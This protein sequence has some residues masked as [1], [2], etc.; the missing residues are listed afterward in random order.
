MAR[1]NYEVVNE[2]DDIIYI[3]DMNQGNMSVTNDAESVCMEL[4]SRY[5]NKRIIYRDSSGQWDELVH[6]EGEFIDY[7]YLGLNDENLLI[8]N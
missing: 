4:H 2:M 1:C 3:V 6:R 5:G 7:K 8:T